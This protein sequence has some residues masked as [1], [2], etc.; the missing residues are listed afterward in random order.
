MASATT[1]NRPRALGLLF[2]S[3]GGGVIACNICHVLHSSTRVAACQVFVEIC[4]GPPIGVKKQKGD[5]TPRGST[6]LPIGSL[7]KA[8]T[9]SFACLSGFKGGFAV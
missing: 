8:E 2:L 4:K 6:G 7:L 5:F 3:G 9:V 1:N